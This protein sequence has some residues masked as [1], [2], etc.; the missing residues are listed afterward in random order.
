MNIQL[1]YNF[2]QI[3][4]LTTDE[5]PLKRMITGVKIRKGLVL[6]GLSQG[7]EETW[8]MEIEFQIEKPIDHILN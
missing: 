5:E 8:H 7:T 1:K 2:G 3:V 4:Y 6:Y